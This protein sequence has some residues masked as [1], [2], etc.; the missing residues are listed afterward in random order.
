MNTKLRSLAAL[1]VASV[2][3]VAAC[4]GSSSPPKTPP[5]KQKTSKT[6]AKTTPAASTAPT[7]ATST[8]SFAGVSAAGLKA[9]AQAC[10]TEYAA[11]GT[12]LGGSAAGDLQNIC[13]AFASGSVANVKAAVAK[14][15]TTDLASLPAVA[16]EAVSAGC[17][18]FKKE[19]GG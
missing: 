18:S 10:H 16:Q 5:A 9:A 14:F 17:A 19:Y 4:G 15:C 7:G 11:L 1:A 13:N 6:P 8:S 2:L 12:V 3:L